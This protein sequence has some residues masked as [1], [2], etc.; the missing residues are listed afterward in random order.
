MAKDADKKA[1]P[2]LEEFSER[3]DA[4]RDDAG[5]DNPKANGPAWGRAMRASSDLL[6]GVFV[7]T[8]LGLGVDHFAGT[9]PLFLIVGVFVGFAAGVRN[10]ARTMKE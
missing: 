2:S 1:P 3:L 7:G 10:I 8:L 4:M 9:S 6:A 5:E